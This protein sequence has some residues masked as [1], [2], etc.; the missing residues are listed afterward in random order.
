MNLL[1]ALVFISDSSLSIAFDTAVLA[2]TA[3][4]TFSVARS[5]S[6]LS[7]NE[8]VSLFNELY[9]LGW[10]Y[11]SFGGNLGILLLRDGFAYYM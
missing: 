8:N 2:L 7:K 4:R 10:S 9:G 1:G 5:M 3:S 11:L 6:R